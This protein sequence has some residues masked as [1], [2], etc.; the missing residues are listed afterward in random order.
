MNF[1]RGLEPSNGFRCA[2]PCDADN[3]TFESIHLDASILFSKDDNGEFDYCKP[4]KYVGT[5]DKICTPANF[6]N[7]SMDFDVD[8]CQ[9]I[10]YADFPMDNSLVTDLGLV[11]DK[12]FLVKRLLKSVL[13]SNQQCS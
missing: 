13:T 11:C 2:L 6:V 10:L 1:L 3:A 8:S 5:G 12:E 9:R 7:E 4:H